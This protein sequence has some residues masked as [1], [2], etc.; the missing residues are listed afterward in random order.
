MYSEYNTLFPEQYDQQEWNA[1]VLGKETE[2]ETVTIDKLVEE[3][4]Q[5]PQFIKMDVEGAELEVLKGMDRFLSVE[6]IAEIM[7]HLA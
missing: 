4:I 1:G 5:Q 3:N 7:A 2:V 6:Q